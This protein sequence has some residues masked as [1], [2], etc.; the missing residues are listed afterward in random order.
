[1]PSLNKQ[2]EI[3]GDPTPGALPA[4]L[5]KTSPWGA[6]A[7]SPGT[8]GVTDGGFPSSP[9]DPWPPAAA[10]RAHPCVERF[11]PGPEGWSCGSCANLRAY[12]FDA[13]SPTSPTHHIHT[14]FYCS[15]DGTNRRVTSPSCAFFTEAPPL[16]RPDCSSPP[17]AAAAHS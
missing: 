16:A 9:P 17:T 14:A 15:I 12:H 13:W 5:N 6:V 3:A 1:M 11:G 8:R 4:S 10:P 2:S 7:D